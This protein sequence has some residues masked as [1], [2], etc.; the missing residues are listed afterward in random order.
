MN[1]FTAKMVPDELG[2]VVSMKAGGG[3]NQTVTLSGIAHRLGLKNEE[4]LAAK[5]N[6][7]N[8]KFRDGGTIIPFFQSEDDAADFIDYL[9]DLYLATYI[10][11]VN[12]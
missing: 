11:G 2:I 7:Y 12:E 6:T 3:W 1:I 10:V 5:A 9:Y 4:Q 8:I